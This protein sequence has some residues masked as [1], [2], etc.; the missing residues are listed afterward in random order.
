MHQAQAIFRYMYY[1]FY[2]F[3]KQ[4]RR[5]GNSNEVKRKVFK[6]ANTTMNANSQGKITI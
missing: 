4:N 6:S 5:G 1:T 2:K 3:N